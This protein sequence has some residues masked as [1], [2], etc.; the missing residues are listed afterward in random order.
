MASVD[1]ELYEDDEQTTARVLKVGKRRYVA[2][3]AWRSIENPS[4][5]FKEARE[6][7][8]REQMNLV[9]LYEGFTKQAGLVD[10]PRKKFKLFDGAYSLAAVLANYLGESW[11]G[12]FALDDG[13]YLLVAVKDGAIIPGF[14]LVG[15]PQEIRDKALSVRR[16]HKWAEIYIPEDEVL[17]Q[18]FAELNV[19]RQEL[20]ELLDLAKHQRSHKLVQANAR[21]G[22][23]L[24]P[25]TMILSVLVVAAG[26][27]VL[28]YVQFIKP[29]H[30][31]YAQL[32]MM[33]NEQDLK[34]R[35]DQAMQEIN[36]AQA[37]PTWLDKPEALALIR[38]CMNRVGQLPTVLVNWPLQSIDC[39]ASAIAGNYERTKG[40]ATMDQVTRV[41]ARYPIVNVQAQRATVGL[42][43]TSPGPR[44]DGNHV[45]N[46]REW[47]KR[48]ISYFQ[49]FENSDAGKLD[50]TPKP[51]PV[52]PPPKASWIKLLGKEKA[53]VAPPWWLT[54]EWKMTLVGLNPE[55]VL[56]QLPL[57]GVVIQSASATYNSDSAQL[58]WVLKGEANTRP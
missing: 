20:A 43:L 46:D 1:Y 41:A 21:L 22:G 45:L 53:Q 34:V 4:Q 24:K 33:Q 42:K 16:A 40:L 10:A 32:R 9:M 47:M 29:D 11:L 19:R 58:T 6:L 35:R 13:N 49:N 52:P 36:E 57:K 28:Y 37:R 25:S 27:A 55:A 7:A 26:A 44:Q 12:V 38:N 56:Q 30:A 50:L 8:R 39:R 17:A 14:D 23:L 54:Y 15:D 2:N 48:W 31:R 5:A 3:M 51:H 18:E